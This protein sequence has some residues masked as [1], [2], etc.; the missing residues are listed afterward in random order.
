MYKKTLI[1]GASL[2]ENRYSNLAIRR[3][4]EKEQHV[5]A[6]G[7]SA[8]E[9]SGIPIVNGKPK[10]NEIDT[11]SVY[12]NPSRQKSYYDYI[13]SCKPN[14]VIF[15]PGTEN[16]ELVNLLEQ[17]QIESAIACTLVLLAT[18]TY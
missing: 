8:G 17:H 7:S 9:V 2:N 3:L 15:N 11:I 13:I 5:I 18:N 10:L 4:A 14:R 6:I 12:L 1:L 16:L